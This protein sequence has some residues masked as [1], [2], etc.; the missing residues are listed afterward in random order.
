[1]AA[2]SLS[3]PVRRL[4]FEISERERIG[5]FVEQ[6]DYPLH[7]ACDGGLLIRIE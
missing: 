6:R 5:V 7:E 1:M 2:R 3:S 4:A